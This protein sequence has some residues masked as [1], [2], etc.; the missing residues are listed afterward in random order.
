VTGDIDLLSSDVIVG[1][2]PRSGAESGYALQLP[3]AAIER[4]SGGAGDEFEDRSPEVSTRLP[5]RFRLRL[6]GLGVKPARITIRSETRATS[7]EPD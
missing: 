1:G 5:A 2:L 3:S 6:R 4:Y 7:S